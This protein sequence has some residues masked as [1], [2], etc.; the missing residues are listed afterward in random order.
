MQCVKWQPVRLIIVC[1]LRVDLQIQIC[2]FLRPPNQT[3]ST[4]IPHPRG[5]QMSIH[6]HTQYTHTREHAHAINPCAFCPSGT[7][8]HARTRTRTTPC[9][10]VKHMCMPIACQ[11]AVSLQRPTHV[12]APTKRVPVDQSAYARCH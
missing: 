9:I 7:V 3:G 10:T 6:E 2:A 8:E 12:R 11:T 4:Q 1:V 5:R